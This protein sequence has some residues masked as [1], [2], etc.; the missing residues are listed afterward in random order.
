MAPNPTYC[1]ILVFFW[2]LTSY[3]STWKWRHDDSETSFVLTANFYL[4]VK[5]KGYGKTPKASFPPP[6]FP[7]YKRSRA[8]A[9][10][11]TNEMMFTLSIFTYA[12][13]RIFKL[14]LVANRRNKFVVVLTSVSKSW[15]FIFMG[16]RYSLLSRS[17]T[18]WRY[19]DLKWWPLTEWAWKLLSVM[20]LSSASPRGG[21]TP[22]WCG[23]IWGL[24]GDFA[25]NFCP[26][27]G[28]NVGN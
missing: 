3:H 5:Q 14:E 23:G 9:Y 1:I 19:P 2:Q 11:F 25:T 6:H 28:G 7:L 18:D 15:K 22:G 13:H 16:V 26:C 24:Y 17:V 27:G 4:L 12:T 10:L 20:H 21:G 8:K